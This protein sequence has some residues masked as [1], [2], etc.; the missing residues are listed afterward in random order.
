MATL[1]TH[2]RHLLIGASGKVILRTANPHS[3]RTATAFASQR[4]SSDTVD[5]SSRP[6]AAIIQRE[7]SG[8]ASSKVDTLEPTVVYGSSLSAAYAFRFE[9]SETSYPVEL[10]TD[11]YSSVSFVSGR[12]AGRRTIRLI[13]DCS[14]LAIVGTATVDILLSIGAKP[15]TV[16]PAACQQLA[17]LTTDIVQGQPY[18][19]ILPMAMTARAEAVAYGHTIPHVTF[20]IRPS[21]TAVADAKEGSIDLHA[22][23]LVTLDSAPP[24]FSIPTI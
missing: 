15:S 17:T 18:S 22:S 5:L 21:S 14:S 23:S 6:V 20:A 24:A 8:A 16:N 9:Q 19:E 2:N 1:L 4:H 13:G 11:A 10:T 3:G 7:A 12:P